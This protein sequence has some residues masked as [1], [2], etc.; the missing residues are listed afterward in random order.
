M[1]VFKRLRTDDQIDLGASTWLDIHAMI[2]M[3]AIDDVVANL[4]DP[5]YVIDT[6]LTAGK[7][8]RR[9]SNESFSSEAFWVITTRRY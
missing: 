2:L 5:E 3:D 9:F 1:T 6:L 7:S 8:H 4:D